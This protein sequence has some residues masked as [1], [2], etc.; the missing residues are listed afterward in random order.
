MKRFLSV[1]L[2]LAGTLFQSCIDCGPQA[3]LTALIT[4]RGDSLQL[5][6]LYALK[7]VNQEA[8]RSQIPLFHPTFTQ[9]TLPISLLSDTA[10]YVFLFKD[11]TD[12]L[13][14]YYDRVFRY[15]GGCGFIADARE[16]QKGPRYKAT[17]SQV[18]MYY[19]PYVPDG[20]VNPFVGTKGGISISVTL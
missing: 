4:F 15:K 1:F 8:V 10:T 18:E 11:R 19:E 9:V 12:T 13:S 20:K 16:P 3:E 17:F 5:D 6:S 14:I 2:L 7:A